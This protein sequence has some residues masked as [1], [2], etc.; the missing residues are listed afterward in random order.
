MTL[1]PM[2]LTPARAGAPRDEPW[3]W[4]G[5]EPARKPHRTRAWRLAVAVLSD[6][7]WHPWS[8]VLTAMQLARVTVTVIECPPKRWGVCC[9]TPSETAS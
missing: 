4:P 3:P 8:G 1:T 9:I 6:G 2:T 7:G 5:F